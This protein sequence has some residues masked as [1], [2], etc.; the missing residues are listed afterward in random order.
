MT[1]L[2]KDLLLNRWVLVAENRSERPNDYA[3]PP[4]TTKEGL[5]QAPTNCPFCPSLETQTPPAVYSACNAEGDW[6]VRVVPN[7]YPAVG[8]AMGGD[9]SGVHEV[10]IES[11][12]HI[13][14]TADLTPKE[15]A[16]VLEAYNARLEHWYE[17][18]RFG[19][20]M[21]FKNVHS[22]AGA[23]LVHL[24][25]QIMVLPEV[26][27]A[28]LQE[29]YQLDR[30]RQE[31][32]QCALCERIARERNDSVRLVLD[33]DGYVA[34]C[35][36]VS[37]HAYET[38]LLPVDHGRWFPPTANRVSTE[39]LAG[40]LWEVLSR[41]ERLLPGVGYNMIV[42]IAPWSAQRTDYH[43]RIEIY[44][45]MDMFAGFE[46][47]TSIHINQVSPEYAAQK[48]R[49]MEPHRSCGT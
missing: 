29:L 42:R 33:R 40:V 15:L 43:P 14:N 28:C 16:N 30:F 45:R 35:P 9:K 10:V 13:Q 17:D 34:I 18:G 41:I 19:Y 25:S 8:T 21:I 22:M 20:A 38:W 7:K 32:D 26:P 5:P 3:T 39:T 31:H 27:P 1:D 2:R 12:R 46:L 11:P 47:G 48:L 6:Q 24:H 36:Y 23:S 4:A 49:A 44:P 37:M